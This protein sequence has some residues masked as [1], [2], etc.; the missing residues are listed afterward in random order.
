MSAKVKSEDSHEKFTNGNLAT[1]SH[2]RRTPGELKLTQ[3]NGIQKSHEVRIS[4]V[5]KNDVL[6][7][8]MKI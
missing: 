6:I 2:T 8:Y 5:F 4:N 1:A 7:S 3:S